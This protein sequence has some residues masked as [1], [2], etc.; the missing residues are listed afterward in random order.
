MAKFSIRDLLL[1]IAI[2]G[3]AFGWWLDRRPIP[4][5]FQSQATTN[6][7]FVLDTATGEIWSQGITSG[8]DLK[9][10][11]RLHRNVLAK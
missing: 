7:I 6:R 1:L 3:L 4:A 10:D 11:G 9:G 5:R 2:V 8:G